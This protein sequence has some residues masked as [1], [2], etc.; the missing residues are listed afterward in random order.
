MGGKTCEVCGG[1]GKYPLVNIWELKRGFLANEQPPKD[2]PMLVNAP[3]AECQYDMFTAYV[4]AMIER[5][6]DPY[7]DNDT[8]RVAYHISEE[9]N[10]VALLEP[11]KDVSD[12]LD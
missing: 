10:K 9:G 2:M 6:G 11:G 12:E 7:P 3:C 4:A 5:H 1:D 8:L